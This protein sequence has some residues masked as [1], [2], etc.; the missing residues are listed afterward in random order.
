M[1]LVLLIAFSQLFFLLGSLLKVA[2]LCGVR[3]AIAATLISFSQLFVNLRS[4]LKVAFFVWS[5][6]CYSS[7]PKNNKSWEKIFKVTF[8]LCF[9]WGGIAMTTT[10]TTTKVGIMFVKFVVLITPF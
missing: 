2:F 5:P 6:D 7:D 9:F 3:I 10:L 1:V 8:C 4:L